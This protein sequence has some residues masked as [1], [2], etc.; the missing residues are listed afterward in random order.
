MINLKKVSPTGVEYNGHFTEI[1][2]CP[3]GIDPKAVSEVVRSKEATDYLAVM[4]KQFAG[5]KV[6]TR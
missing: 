1:C 4:E 3:V 5:R 2:I 6:S